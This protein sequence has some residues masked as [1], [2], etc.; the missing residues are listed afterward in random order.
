MPGPDPFAVG[1]R[2]PKDGDGSANMDAAGERAI[3]A[4]SFHALQGLGGAGFSESWLACLGAHATM[5]Q[6]F[7]PPRPATQGGL[8]REG[9]EWRRGPS[10]GC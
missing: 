1:R 8:G 4:E 10:T 9:R 7:G 6:G 3:G 5:V 2:S